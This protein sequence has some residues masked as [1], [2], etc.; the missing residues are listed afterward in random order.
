M[1]DEV[2]KDLA[3]RVGIAAE[4]NDFAGRP[5]LVAP[6]V[7]RRILDALGLPT[8]TRS[9]LLHS[10]KLLQRRS[11]V[12]T[13]PP[14]ITATAGRPTRLD[15]G[16]SEAESAQLKL[17]GGGTRNL[18][19]T[20][21][22]GR[23]RVPAISET[24]YHRLQLGDRELVIAVAPSR[25]HSID[26]TVPDARLWG[27]A[28][29]VYALRHPGDGGIG[30]A[31]GVADLAAAA[32][33]RGA[34]A[35][36]LSPLHAL[37]TADPERFGPY[38]PSSRLFL[39]PLHASAEL[40]FGRELV[41]E[42]LQ[43]QRIDGAFQA[44]EAAQL[45]DWPKAAKAKLQL[46]RALF[47]AFL[48]RAEDDCQLHLDFASFRAD[49]GSLLFQ[50][51][52][53]ETLH[54]T[55][56]ADGAGDW[57]RWATDLRD[58][59]SAA[60]SVFAGSHEQEVMFHCFLQWVADRSLRAAQ[61]RAVAS[62]MR[63][64]LI[65]DLAVGMDP[66]GSHAWSRQDEV[67]GGMSIG[68]PPDLFNPRGQ[69][70]GLTSFSPRALAAGGFAPFIATLRA[71]LRNTGGIRIDHVMG[72]TRLWLVP[73]GADPADG[74]Y[75]A[76][77]LTDLLRLLALESQRHRAIV[78]GEDLGTVPDGFQATLETAGLHGM[79][80]LWF[81]RNGQG[82][83]SPRNWSQTAV[84]MT[85]THDLPTVAGWWRGT[86]IKIR[87]ATG[88]LGAGQN[89]EDL[90]EE[91]SGDRTALWH[92]LVTQG[93]AEGEAPPPHQTKPVV[94][95][96]LRLVAVTPAPLCL[97]PIE[98]LLGLE[99]QPNLP[100][101]VDEHPNWRRRLTPCADSLLDQPDVAHRVEELAT[102]RPRL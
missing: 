54:A 53:F 14:L 89:E 87:A 4:W 15:V 75:L 23:L 85:C 20:S 101:T 26:D 56:S 5:K 19:L 18:S 91:R 43:S 27:I 48:E 66:A 96:A 86:D 49:G 62:G 22:R 76:Y 32:G 51:A 95:A 13:L 1:N 28:A 98:D 69:D 63:I 52:V 57:R 82:F 61:R 8:A 12:Q 33:A 83:A 31:A 90:G 79:R 44:L 77:P 97:P 29:Q 68:A 45:I 10:R 93:V 67:L 74:A 100:G 80:V 47:D 9:D 59:N 73:E 42:A 3:R 64:G 41:G 70:W 6:D 78:I 36:A 40:V 99:E 65:G 21:V 35:L 16:A 81:E 39:N 25:C 24:G 7:L 50:H 11:T 102:E 60:V 34:D 38:S 46:L 37:F 72:L 58:P 71:V 30:D 55:Q 2:L 94:D 17:E 92:A 84:A 88:R